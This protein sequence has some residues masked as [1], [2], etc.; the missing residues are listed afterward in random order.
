MQDIR[1]KTLDNGH[2]VLGIFFMKQGQQIRQKRGFAVGRNTDG[3]LA[4]AILIDVGEVGEQL[5]VGV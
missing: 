4:D 5:V 2:F 1:V 3:N